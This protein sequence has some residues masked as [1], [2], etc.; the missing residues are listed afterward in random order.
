MEMTYYPFFVY[1]NI[2]RTY[3]AKIVPGPVKKDL[4]VFFAEGI[5]S[6]PPVPWEAR[7][8]NGYPRV[9]WDED[10]KEY[11]CYYSNFARDEASS[12]YSLKERIGRDYDFHDKTKYPNPRIHSLLMAR[13]K[14][15]IS[16][17]RPSLGAVEFN[18]SK[19]NNIV[20]AGWGGKVNVFR[21]AHEKDPAKRY[22][23]IGKNHP[24]NWVTVSFSPDGIHFCDPIPVQ[25]IG[26]GDHT[27]MADTN[28]YAFW[29]E[30][31]NCYAL[32]TRTWE[33]QIFRLSNRCESDDFIHWTRPREIY[34]SDGMDDQLYAMPVFQRAGVYI[35]LGSIFHVGDMGSADFDKVD[36]ELLYSLDCWHFIPVAAGQPLIKRGKGEYGSGAPDSGTIYASPPV[37]I[38]GKDYIYYIGGNGQHTNY[39]EGSLLRVEVDLD[40]LA[41]YT[42]RDAGEA[43]VSTCDTRITGSEIRFKADIYEGGIIESCI[44]YPPPSQFQ[45]P[46]GFGRAVIPEQG[47]DYKDSKIEKQS[48][49]SYRVVYAG[50]TPDVFKDKDVRIYFRFVKTTLYGIGGDISPVRRIGL[51]DY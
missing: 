19:D 6:N 16:W 28:N 10:Y 30:T 3:N 36:L 17:E 11:R 31:T 46:I 32:I 25:W 41:G 47:F 50:G 4:R 48:D 1:N 14:D 51:W 12:R 45:G 21:D 34:R 35:G 43:V 38:D 9:F 33:S 23:M 24:P 27:P 18:G 2:G 26:D 29:D 5:L 8:D 15:G 40:K 44:A 49:G 7:F 13:S 42:P 22:K 37:R 39:R 20:M